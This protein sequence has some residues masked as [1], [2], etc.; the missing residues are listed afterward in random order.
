MA[1]PDSAA[2]WPASASSP[3]ETSIIEVA[4]ASAAVGPASYGG[5]GR[6]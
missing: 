2:R 4:P 1:T 3:S 5:S 6:R